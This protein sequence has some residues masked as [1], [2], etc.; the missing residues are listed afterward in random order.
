MLSDHDPHLR[1]KVNE[2]RA[3]LKTMYREMAEDNKN[4]ALTTTMIHIWQNVK[5]VRLEQISE[6]EGLIRDQAAKEWGPETRVEFSCEDFKVI[7]N[8]P[9][10][11]L[12]RVF[13]KT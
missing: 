9:A 11:G 3:D 8:N 1:R 5:D 13:K 7:V 12:S 4:L 2:M 10:R 6:L